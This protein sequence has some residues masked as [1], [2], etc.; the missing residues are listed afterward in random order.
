MATE[1]QPRPLLTVSQVAERL[2]LSTKQ[3]RRRISSGHLPA[4][5]LGPEPQA[6]LRVDADE[7]DKWLYEDAS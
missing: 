5:K 6:H 4:L 1:A 2:S 3:V 7:L